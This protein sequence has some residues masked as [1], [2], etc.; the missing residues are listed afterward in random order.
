[1]TSSSVTT[2][3]NRKFVVLP[4]KTKHEILKCF[5]EAVYGV[6]LSKADIVKTLTIAGSKLKYNKLEKCT[7]NLIPKM[8]EKS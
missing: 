4:V 3:E 1:M 7:K 8:F 2:S 6:L 5:A